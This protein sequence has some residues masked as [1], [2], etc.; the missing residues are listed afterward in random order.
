MQYTIIQALAE[1]VTRM[2][3]V[4]TSITSIEQKSDD[5]T[6]W[7]VGINGVRYAIVNVSEQTIK[8]D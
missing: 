6:E 8:W 1:M 3:I 2:K 5:G 7:R 4:V